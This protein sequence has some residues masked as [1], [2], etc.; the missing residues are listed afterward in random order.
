MN[1][2]AVFRV[3]WFSDLGHFLREVKPGE[4]GSRQRD[5]PGFEF[6]CC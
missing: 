5:V 1:G 3:K 2:G 6:G 4:M